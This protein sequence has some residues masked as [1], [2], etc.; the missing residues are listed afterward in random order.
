VLLSS[1]PFEGK[2]STF[3][4]NKKSGSFETAFANQKSA[5]MKKVE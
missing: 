3:P 4:K 2:Q 1:F 5:K